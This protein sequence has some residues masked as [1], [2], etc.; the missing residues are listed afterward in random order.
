MLVCVSADNLCERTSETTPG[1]ID[2]VKRV[3]IVSPPSVRPSS[4][5]AGRVP[6]PPA[7]P[8][9]RCDIYT[10]I[11]QEA[12]RL[13]DRLLRVSRPVCVTSLMVRV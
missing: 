13:G 4:G 3:T 9:A 7:G 12:A 5:H 6:A 8:Q 1:A 11:P 2:A 10:V